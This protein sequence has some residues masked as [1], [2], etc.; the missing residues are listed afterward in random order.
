MNIGR[1][2]KEKQTLISR[3]QTESCWKGRWVEG[4]LATW[5]MGIKEGT[6]NEHW[7]S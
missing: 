4:G 3:E 2:K 5:L 6:C 7:V 1:G